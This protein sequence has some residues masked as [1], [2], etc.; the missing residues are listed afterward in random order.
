MKPVM[1]LLSGGLDSTVLLYDLIAQECRVHC[2]LI[3]YGQTHKRELELAK[4]HCFQTKTLYTCVVLPQLKGSLLTDGTGSKIVPNRN[5][6]FLS[7]AISL[8]A[9]AKAEAVTI[10]C[11]KD[12]AA[13]FPDCRREFIEAMTGAA[14]AAG[15]GVEVCAPYLDFPKRQVVQIGR[16]LSVPLDHTWSCYAGNVDPCGVCDACIKRA[17]AMQ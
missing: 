9:S 8:A 11:N 1:H 13:D 7:F 3:D 2:L 10:G 6:I 4:W 15:T 16:K 5:A 14:R 17:E 12:D